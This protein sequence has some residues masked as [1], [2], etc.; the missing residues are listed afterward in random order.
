MN[1]MYSEHQVDGDMGATSVVGS[2]RYVRVGS[3]AGWGD[4]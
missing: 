2:G 1:E 4:V 3:G